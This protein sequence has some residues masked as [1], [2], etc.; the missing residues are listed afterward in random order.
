MLNRSRPLPISLIIPAY[1]AEPYIRNAL[2]S[3][4]AQ[5][6]IPAEIIVVDDGSTDRTAAVAADCGATVLRLSSNAGP[7]AARNAGIALASEPWV[8]FLDADDVWL[9]DKL[10]AQWDALV[11]WPD[12]GFC[13]SDYDVVD[14]A[15]HVRPCEMATDAGYVVAEASARSGSAVRFE[16]GALVAGLVRS[17]FIRQSSVI[18]DRRLLCSSGC[19]DERLRLGEDYDLFLR[20]IARAPGIAIERPLV[21]YHRRAAS[22]S[23]DPLA[24]IESI[25]RLWMAIL[26]RPDRY[27]A[28]VVDLIA[29]QRPPCAWAGSPKHS[30]SRAEPARVITRSRPGP[31]SR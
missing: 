20:V 29:E 14:A 15:G 18:I 31:C 4:A 26:Q 11:R 25:D 19:Y 10:A 28:A 6:R 22:L 12:A 23:V 16:R 30:R 9:D 2:Q 13:F 8:A 21:A 17:M 3:V 27:P 1:Q 24:E 5:S 7:S